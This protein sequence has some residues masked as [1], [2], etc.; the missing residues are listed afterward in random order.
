MDE[1]CQRRVFPVE[2]EKNE[3]HHWITHI[4]IRPGA[5]FLGATA[6]LGQLKEGWPPT[7][8]LDHVENSQMKVILDQVNKSWLSLA[9]PG[10][11][12]LTKMQN[13]LESKI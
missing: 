8:P 10:R 3:Q 4:R 12:D 5:I 11:V 9:P 2:N 1:I 13:S 6:L 7:A